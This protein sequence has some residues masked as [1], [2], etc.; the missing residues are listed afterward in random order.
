MEIAGC[1]YDNFAEYNLKERMA[2]NSDTVYKLL[3][4]LLEAHM[5]TAQ[6][7]MTKY[8]HWH[9]VKTDFILMP[10]TGVITLKA[11]R[12]KFSINDEMLRPCW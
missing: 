11:E 1:W 10:W 9:A 5:R 12:R 6:K 8:R 3:N 2:Q 7:N 4:Q